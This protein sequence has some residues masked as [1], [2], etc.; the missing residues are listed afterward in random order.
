[1]QLLCSTGAFS[2]FPELTD[3]RS[4]LEYGPLLAVDGLEVMFFPGWMDDIEDIAAGLRDSGLRLSVIHAEQGIGPALISSQPE[5][6]GHGWPWL[7]AGCRLGQVV[8][9]KTLFFA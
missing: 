9:V 4:I 5:E 2:R 7:Q 8:G 6:R 1:M 3:Y